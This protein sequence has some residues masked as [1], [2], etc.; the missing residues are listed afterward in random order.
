MSPEQCVTD[1][2]HVDTGVLAPVG[3][4]RELCV[5]G[6]GATHPGVPGVASQ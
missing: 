5:T 6:L 1:P 3:T 4:H 2:Q